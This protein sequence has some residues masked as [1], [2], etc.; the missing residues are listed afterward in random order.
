MDRLRRKVERKDLCRYEETPA[1]VP[2]CSSASGRA[3]SDG[4]DSH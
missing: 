1:P 4:L 2:F 3:K